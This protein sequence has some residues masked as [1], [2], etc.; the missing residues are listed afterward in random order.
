MTKVLITAFEPYDRWETNS[1]W[2]AL[3][4]FARSLPQTP[5]V[6]TRLYP[7]DLEAVEQRL[8][9]DLAADYDVALHLGQAPGSAAIRLEAV[10][11]NVAINGRHTGQDY[12][13]LR[14][15]GPVAY[16]SRLP[17]GALAS[18]LRSAGIPAHVSFHAGTYL[19][20][21]LLYLSH[22]LVERK[23]LKTKVAFM[24]V[25]LDP[26][27]VLAAAE[28]LPSLPATQTAAALRMIVESCAGEPSVRRDPVA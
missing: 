12:E 9:T 28:E 23:R 5:R 4:E 26:A 1:S 18:T 22:L 25:P 16:R 14:K 19:C 21:A 8:S 2:L 7:V 6:T 20:N 13:L 27:Q 10:G 3:V 15:D 17:L 11:L 24:H